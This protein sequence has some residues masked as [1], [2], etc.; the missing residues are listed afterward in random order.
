MGVDLAAV[1]EI[2]Q[3]DLPVLKNHIQMISK[4]MGNGK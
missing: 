3:G 1:W 2:T 4:E